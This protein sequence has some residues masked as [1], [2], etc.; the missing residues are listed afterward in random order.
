MKR[1]GGQ[2]SAR[3]GPRE[4][5]EGSRP[6]LTLG[7]NDFAD[8]VLLGLGGDLR[9]V[10]KRVLKFLGGGVEDHGLWN[11]PLHSPLLLEGVLDGLGDEGREE[12]VSCWDIMG[13]ASG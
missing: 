13:V 10:R 1:S 11:R 8:A 12:G 2:V 5:W 9:N 4:G 3:P 7:G 6:G